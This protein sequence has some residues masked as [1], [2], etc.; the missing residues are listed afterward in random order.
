[1]SYIFCGCQNLNKIKMSYTFITK[2]VVNFYGMFGEYENIKYLDLSSFDTKNA[3]I[4][5]GMF[6]RCYNL[7]KINFSS[8]FN[9]KN[10]T[11]MSGMFSQCESLETLDL[12]SFDTK[13][14]VIMSA[15]FMNVII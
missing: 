5:T 6:C 4:M 12:S 3:N 8:S 10:V 13:K 9:T 7:K 2:K 1:M 14:V 11:N 15:C